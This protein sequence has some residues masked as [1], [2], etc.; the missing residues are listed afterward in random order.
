ME[1]S[2]TEFIF[3]NFFFLI[4]ILS[5]LVKIGLKYEYIIFF[6]DFHGNFHITKF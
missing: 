6:S 5:R 4:F 2:K 3:P 1:N